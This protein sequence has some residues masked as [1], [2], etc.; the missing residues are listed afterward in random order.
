MKIN[1]CSD[2]IKIKGHH[3]TWYVIDEKEGLFLLEHEQYGDETTCLIVNSEGETVCDNVWD[4]CSNL[5]YDFERV[6]M[7]MTESEYREYI[8]ENVSRCNSIVQA[9]LEDGGD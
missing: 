8:C 6:L 5:P 4:D 7:E 9:A 3:G 1:R 2:N